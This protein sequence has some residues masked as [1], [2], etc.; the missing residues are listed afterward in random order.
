MKDKIAAAIASLID[1]AEVDGQSL[2]ANAKG[3]ALT[4]T[5]QGEEF[6]AQIGQVNA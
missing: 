2:N 4:V 1:G 6:T 3:D 5:W